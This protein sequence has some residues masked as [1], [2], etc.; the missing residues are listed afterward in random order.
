[1]IDHDSIVIRIAGDSGDGVQLVGEQL[2]ITAAL[3][4][5]EVQTLP[6]YPAEIRAPAGTVA[7]V[8]G[9]QLAM[10]DEPIFTAGETCDVLVAL[11]PA[12]LKQS[13]PYLDQDGILIVN[14]DSLQDKDWE[15]AHY[16]SQHFQDIQS[17]YQLFSIPIIQLTLQAIEGL[18]LSQS[19]G[20][21]A[22][23]C[24]ILGLVLW[25]FEL[26]TTDCETFLTTKFKN[27]QLL[28]QA[29]LRALLAGYNYAMTLELSRRPRSLGHIN[30][31][32]GEYRHITGIE[33]V[34]LGIAAVAT[35]TQ[36][37]TLGRIS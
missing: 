24:Y 25:L 8:S 18:G 27:N 21:K 14:S 12:A 7:G 30:R 2:T 19:E 35:G 4:G 32:P 33:A 20:K 11:N 26:P 17:Q 10:S 31:V 37:Q 28:Q 1:M 29:N 13:L 16:D 22:K 3:Q 36:I 34:A 15:K 9:F 23:N 6:D 5:R